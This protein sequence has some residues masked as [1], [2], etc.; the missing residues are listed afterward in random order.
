MRLILYKKKKIPLNENG[1]E[2]TIY[3]WIDMRNC[4]INLPQN[5]ILFH[6]K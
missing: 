1:E 3:F 4:N 5:S 6:N 2:K